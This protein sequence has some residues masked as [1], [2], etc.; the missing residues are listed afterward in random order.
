[1]ARRMAEQAR[2]WTLMTAFLFI[3]TV[4]WQWRLHSN[5]V[6]FGNGIPSEP[7]T[8]DGSLEYTSRSTTSNGNICPSALKI[9]DTATEIDIAIANNIQFHQQGG[10]L[11]SIEEYLNSHMDS[12]LQS[13][14]VQF[15]P[16]GQDKPTENAIDYLQDH[17]KKNSVKRGG[18]GQPLPGDLSSSYGKNIINKAL[19]ENRW[20]NVIEPPKRDRFFAGTGP[21]GPNCSR[22][23]TFSE[24][25]YE[26]KKLC[27]AS[28]DAKQEE[29]KEKQE[30]CNI[31]SI[32]SNDQWGFEEDVMQK[33]PGCI[34]H[35]FDCT[36]KDM[37]PQKKPKTDNIK[38]YPYCIGSN[39]AQHPYLSYENIWS[40]T[41]I[42]TPPK[43]LK[44]DVEGFEYDVIHT[45]LS[46]DQ[47]IWPEQIMMEVHWGTRMVDL[48]WMPRT[49]TA[50]EIALF[51]G[52]LFNHGGYVVVDS[53]TFAKGCQ[54]CMEVLL[55][56]VVC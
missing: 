48:P 20:I 50:A 8:H 27:V 40:K 35:T 44:M 9:F 16:N 2:A 31:L 21:V 1:M 42:K 32:G 6:D 4:V 49:R 15:T 7:A 38:F 41:Q 11:H 29:S 51:F 53:K 36:L 45:M 30:E 23:V 54:P 52:E 10:N 13:L 3:W 37:T 43:L 5:F 39:D 34:T 55:V 12:T 47:S 18:Y 26:E 14:N 24:G 19:F 17:Y 33:L 46:S 28:K 56:R 25:T 22:K